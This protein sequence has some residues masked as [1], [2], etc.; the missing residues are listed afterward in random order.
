MGNKVSQKVKHILA[1]K[2]KH[3][4]RLCITVNKDHADEL[5]RLYKLHGIPVSRIIEAC[6]ELGL[7]DESINPTSGEVEEV[8]D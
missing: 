1:E 5:D 6:I 3:R 7:A 8:F 4:E 2:E